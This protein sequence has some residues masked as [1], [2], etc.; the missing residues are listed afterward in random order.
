MTQFKDLKISTKLIVLIGIFLVGFFVFGYFT[1]KGLRHIEV[2]GP[3]Y[4]QIVSGKDLVADILPPPEYIIETHLTSYQMLL[5]VENGKQADQL[6]ALIAKASEL[7]QEFQERNEY[8]KQALPEGNL[9]Q[10]LIVSASQSAEEY[11]KILNTQ[12]IPAIQIKDAAGARIILNDS[13]TPVYSQHRQA[14]DRLAVLAITQNSQME[15]AAAIDVSQLNLQ[16][17]LIGLGAAI[18]AAVL[19]IVISRGIVKPVKEMVRVAKLIANGDITQKVAFT[20]R[21]EVGQL[22]DAFRGMS[23]YLQ[24]ISS[25]AVEEMACK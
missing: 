13:L 10:E 15:A 19:G 3:V 22:A 21:D 14:I 23:L 1:M 16:L 17:I 18:V 25:A 7:Q 11:F 24:A 5:A 12:Y 20:S 2:N 9:K 4:Q 8:W 6:A